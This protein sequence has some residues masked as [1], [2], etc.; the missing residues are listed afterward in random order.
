MNKLTVEQRAELADKLVELLFPPPVKQA[1]GCW[2]D[3]GVDE[4]DGVMID[5]CRQGGKADE[6]CMGTLRRVQNKL[7]EARQ[8]IEETLGDRFEP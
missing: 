4:L 1:H 8:L 6:V 2:L 5:I 3:S 7:E